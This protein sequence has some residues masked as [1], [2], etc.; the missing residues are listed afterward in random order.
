MKKLLLIL[1]LI[2]FMP[3][4]SAMYDKNKTVEQIQKEICQENQRRAQEN[5]ANADRIQASKK[6]MYGTILA[7]G[8]F[9]LCA[10]QIACAINNASNNNQ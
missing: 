6:K 2:S 8:L 5:R 9:G 10:A 7:V 4:I 3:Q 1:T